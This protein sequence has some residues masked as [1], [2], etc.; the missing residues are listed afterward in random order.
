MTEFSKLFGHEKGS[1]TGASGRH[2]G[3]FEQADQGTIFLDE[4]GDMPWHIGS[5]VRQ[6]D[7]GSIAAI[8]RGLQFVDNP[9]T[10]PAA[11]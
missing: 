7:S 4:I 1:F 5:R 10:A 9:Q 3:K 6:G 2:I 11:V 8:R